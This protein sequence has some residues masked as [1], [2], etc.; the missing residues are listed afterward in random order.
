[1]H[2]YMCIEKVWKAIQRIKGNYYSFIFILYELFTRSVD[3]V[4]IIFIK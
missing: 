4:C 1:M 3:Y 2:A